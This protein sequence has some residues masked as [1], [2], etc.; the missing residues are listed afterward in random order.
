[1]NDESCR[2]EFSHLFVNNIRTHTPQCAVFDHSDIFNISEYAC[3]ETGLRIRQR[4]REQTFNAILISM[5]FKRH[6]LIFSAI[7]TY[8]HTQMHFIWA[9]S[10]YR[11][12]S[13]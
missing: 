2:F 4:K 9:Y 13:N 5:Q 7:T 12:K 6:G 1:M 3:Q 11:I 8:T 10:I